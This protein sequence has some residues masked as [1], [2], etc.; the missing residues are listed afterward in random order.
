[1]L[2]RQLRIIHPVEQGFQQLLCLKRDLRFKG[3]YFREEHGT[4]R[5]VV[6]A[7][8]GNIFRNTHTMFSGRFQ[9]S[10]D[11]DIAVKEDHFRFFLTFQKFIHRRFTSGSETGNF[12]EPLL[13]KRQPGIGDMLFETPGA[14][15]AGKPEIADSGVTA[16]G[17]VFKDL[18]GIL[19]LIRVN[20]VV[21]IA[22][23]Y[24]CY[25]V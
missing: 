3:G 14:Q 17:D 13:T 6:V 24:N 4:F 7:D 1:M 2:N 9:H 25:T 20:A 8:N 11:H 5:Q 16:G 15:F 18:I 10:A 19:D 22:I 23:S 12:D 21:L